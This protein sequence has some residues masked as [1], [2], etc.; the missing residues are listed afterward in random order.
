MYKDKVIKSPEVFSK[1]A[2]FDWKEQLEENR[3]T[4]FPSRFCEEACTLILKQQEEIKQLRS[5]ITIGNNMNMKVKLVEGKIGKKQNAPEWHDTVYP[6]RGMVYT[7][8][9]IRMDCEND[10]GYK[11]KGNFVSN[12]F[13]FPCE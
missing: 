1:H 7:V 5:N 3:K 12:T 11:I 9:D 2:E 10:K 13:P 8:T 6:I 4:I